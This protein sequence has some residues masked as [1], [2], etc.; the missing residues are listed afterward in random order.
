MAELLDAGLLHGDCLTVTGKTIAENLADL[1]P[2]APD[3]TVVHPLGDAIHDRGGIAVLRGSLAPKGSVVKVAGIDVDRFEGTA[4]VFD[5][6]AAAMEEILA[7]R[8]QPRRH[9]GHPLRGPQGRSRHAGDAGGHRRDEGRRAGR[10]MPRSSPTAGSPAA[11][12]ASASATSPPR[13]STAAPSRSSPTATASSSTSSATS[14]TST[15]TRPPSRPAG[16]TGSSPSPATPRAS[17]P[18]TPPW[19]KAPKR[20]P[21][22]SPDI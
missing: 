17:W 11:P 1:D 20:A 6:E 19:P 9:R 16:P 15:S 21:S 10:R 12:T 7:G 3:G 18:S 2:P 22:P 13:R 14:S 5:G 8:H 4:R